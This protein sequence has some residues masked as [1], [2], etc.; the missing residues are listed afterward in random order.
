M[1][2]KKP[3]F[4]L[5]RVFRVLNSGTCNLQ[6]YSRS[7]SR[8]PVICSSLLTPKNY[9]TFSILCCVS[10]I[11]HSAL[12]VALWFSRVLPVLSRPLYN[13]TLP[14][15]CPKIGLRTASFVAWGNKITCYSLM[16]L[17]TSEV[18]ECKFMATHTRDIPCRG[19]VNRL[20]SSYVCFLL[21][22]VCYQSWRRIPRYST[23]V[24]HSKSHPRIGA[25]VPHT[26]AP[27]CS[28]QTHFCT[29]NSRALISCFVLYLCF[30]RKYS[31]ASKMLEH[32]ST[33]RITIYR[34]FSTPTLDLA[35]LLEVMQ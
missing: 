2:S 32:H 13:L 20:W 10:H 8:V 22:H 31:S 24:I 23:H 16:R 21:G 17:A 7:P 15:I 4:K 1:Q 5:E 6:T 34:R 3:L 33:Q 14:P 30:A 11:F 28:L 29:E 25:L 12:H 26:W 18:E 9:N 27:L 19:C 35:S